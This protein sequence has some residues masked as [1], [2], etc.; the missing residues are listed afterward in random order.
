MTGEVQR[1]RIDLR[2]EG[3]EEADQGT[4]RGII[5]ETKGMTAEIEVTEMTKERDQSRDHHRNHR[6]YCP[7]ELIFY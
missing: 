1:R 7:N 3:I 4:I 5:I 2:R 6:H